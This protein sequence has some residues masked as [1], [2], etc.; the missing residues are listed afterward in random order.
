MT[1]SN[2]I[3]CIAIA[4]ILCGCSET[5][6]DVPKATAGDE[7]IF[8]ASMPLK[9]KTEYGI[10]GDNASSRPVY[11]SDGD[12]VNVASP[13]CMSNRNIA[14]Y[15][16]SVDTKGMK[17]ANS[18]NK[19]GANGIQWGET[20]AS[21]CKFYAVYPSSEMTMSGSSVTANLS[22]SS[23]QEVSLV[24]VKDKDG[25]RYAVSSEE[26][27]N[28]IMYAQPIQGKSQVTTDDET[29]SVIANLQFQPYSTVLH[30]NMDGWK[31]S[32]QGLTGYDNLIIF[33][34]TITAPSGTSIAGSF[35]LTFSAEGFSEPTLGTITNGE[36][37]TTVY[38]KSGELN[39]VE[40]EQNVPFSFD[41]FMIPLS[42]VSITKDWTISVTTSAG[43]WSK[44]LEVQNSTATKLTP[45]S[46]HVLPKLPAFSVENG[47]N[48]HPE[49]WLAD[50]ED[51][52]YFTELSLPGSWYSPNNSDEYSADT[53]YQLDMSI[54]EQYNSGIRAFY[55]E[56]RVGITGG[57]FTYSP[58][59]SN[60][61][62]E[63]VTKRE[64]DAILVLSGLGGNNQS[65]YGDLNTYYRAQSAKEAI[66][67]VSDA[68]ANGSDS[69]FAVLCLSYADGGS[70]GV[71]GFWRVAW[72]QKIYD[73]VSDLLANND[74][75][76]KVL[77]QKEITPETTIKE[78]RG[79]LIL[80]I[81]IDSDSE[82]GSVTTTTEILG[83]ASRTDT[84]D[85]ALFGKIPAL[86]SFTN[87]TWSSTSLVSRLYWS[88]KPDLKDISDFSD[89]FNWNYT[90]ANQTYART[91]P[92]IQN[93]NDAINDLVVN[94]F[95][96]R[97][98]E[99]HNILFMIGAGGTQENSP[100]TIANELNRYLSSLIDD[101]V[102]KGQASPLGLVY[103]N[104]IGTQTGQAL[105]ESIIRMNR[106]FELG[107]KANAGGSAGGPEAATPQND[108]TVQDGGNA[109]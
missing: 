73:V 59:A 61:L 29:G 13:Q 44:N 81:N 89:G 78:L 66:I 80:K 54:Q 95:E 101:K 48:Y 84:V 18:L 8:A 17:Y 64:N 69:E 58:F 45:G 75:F 76:K 11:W 5:R 40:L 36:N 31:L 27:I 43:K 34:V 46:I 97:N 9:T 14:E 12:K 56:T 16:V 77:Y 57:D 26:M 20:N 102:N 50:I 92:T 7:V 93:R 79:H 28:N 104:Q 55:F 105:I 15:S 67:K 10:L 103:F 51:N 22:I 3:Y 53:D 106:R 30:F 109:I 63:A 2:H 19:T 62:S 47:W 23:A 38:F 6:I 100:A 83:T 91:S 90:L 88:S 94:S 68:V 25:D 98:K 99:K 86:F 65:I 39:G 70:A 49:T 32:D 52:V 42:G 96:R 4:L 82:V 72:L 1:K 33:S 85:E 37:S 87:Y 35:P 41:L 21:D 108:A 24:K 107:K 60:R 74:N 71:S